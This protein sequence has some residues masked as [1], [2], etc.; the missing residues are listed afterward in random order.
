MA[1]SRLTISR[2]QIFSAAA[3]IVPAPNEKYDT[4]T[5]QKVTLL[6]EYSFMNSTGTYGYPTSLPYNYEHEMWI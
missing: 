3:R 5:T 2:T 4:Q 1:S 6:E